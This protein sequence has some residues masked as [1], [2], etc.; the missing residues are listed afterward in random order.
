MIYVLICSAL[1]QL[2]KRVTI[3]QDELDTM[4]KGNRRK[5]VKKFSNE[6]LTPKVNTKVVMTSIT[7]LVCRNGSFTS[8]FDAIHYNNA[9]SP[10]F[11]SHK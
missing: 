10:A 3:L 5:K 1:L 7:Y 8:I 4:R 11:K 2:S 6:K 9:S